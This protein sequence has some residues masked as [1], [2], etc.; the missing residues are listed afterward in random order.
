MAT[1]TLT[2]VV[3]KQ[4][5]EEA[6]K[7]RDV[8]PISGFVYFKDSLTCMQKNNVALADTQ[9]VRC[10]HAIHDNREFYLLL[11]DGVSDHKQYWA[12]WEEPHKWQGY[13]QV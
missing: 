10:L 9:E 4:I 6:V 8:T 7:N 5:V 13:I 1:S 3:K 2:D 11:L 12:I